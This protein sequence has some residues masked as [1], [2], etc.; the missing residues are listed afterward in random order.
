MKPLSVYRRS[1]VSGISIISSVHFSGFSIISF[2]RFGQF[3]T[4]IFEKPLSVRFLNT[5]SP[6][7]EISPVL[8][9]SIV[10]VIFSIFVSLISNL[11]DTP[12]IVNEFNVVG[13]YPSI[14]EI[15]QF[16]PTIGHSATLILVAFI[17]AIFNVLKLRKFLKSQENPVLEISNV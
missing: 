6:F 4:E 13:L 1:F 12:D 15:V 17:D 8:S 14:P 10:K 3:L 11:P 9:G 5:W 16:S 2:S 7:I